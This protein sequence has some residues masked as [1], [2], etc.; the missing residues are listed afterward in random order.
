GYRFGFSAGTDGHTGLGGD[1]RT[2]QRGN[3]IM[4]KMFRC[5]KIPGGGLMAVYARELTRE[6]LWES[7]LKRRIYGTTGARIVLEFWIDDHFMGDEFTTKK[8]PKIN[9]KI[10]SKKAL[11]SVDIIRNGKIFRRFKVKSRSFQDEIMD[12]HP[13][14]N[15]NYYY[16]RVIREDKEMAWSSP[17]W[18]KFLQ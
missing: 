13:R 12:E 10:L 16:L 11:K 14:A 5:E 4:R 1:Y 2:P 6:T 18:L 7:F 9:F 3:E 17:I 8:P 15:F